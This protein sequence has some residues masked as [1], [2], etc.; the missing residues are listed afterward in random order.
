[1][2]CTR[3][4]SR[5][6]IWM[7]ALACC[8]L[9]N[10]SGCSLFVMAGKMLQGDP[11]IDSP[12]TKIYG[13]SMEKS[14]KKVAVLCNTPESVKSEFSSLDLDL[15][16]DISRKLAAQRIDI[17]EN[18]RIAKWIDDYGGDIDLKELGAEIDVDL[19]IQVNFNQFD[20]REENSSELFRGRANGNIVVYELVRDGDSS[21]KFESKPRSDEEKE[22]KENGKS[23]ETKS[24]KRGHKKTLASVKFVRKVYEG[25]FNSTYP[26]LQPVSITQMQ[27]DTFRRKF[28][29]RMGDEVARLFYNHK[30]GVDI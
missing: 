30:A 21:N 29:D 19:I 3:R 20:Y 10:V 1:M 22:A 26:T 2:P 12:F 9:V 14:G 27:P 17:V 5:N 23:K 8:L 13:K 11:L 16:A 7:A 6:P 4:P 24:K 25:S 15:A 28:L 18:H